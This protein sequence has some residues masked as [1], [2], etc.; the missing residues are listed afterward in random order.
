MA[1]KKPKHDTALPIA[2]IEFAEERGN[3]F[4]KVALKSQRKHN[5]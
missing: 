3:G 1:K 2:D 5:K 4:E